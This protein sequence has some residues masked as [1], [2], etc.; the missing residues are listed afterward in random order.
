MEL[1]T[2]VQIGSREQKNDN[3]ASIRETETI[4]TIKNADFNA[5]QS[6]PKIEIL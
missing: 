2:P 1:Q 6:T 3:L 4:R 5:S